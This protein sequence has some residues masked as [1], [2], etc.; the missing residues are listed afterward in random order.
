MSQQTTDALTDFGSYAFDAVNQL[1]AE[2]RKLRAELEAKDRELA[3][4][5]MHL[6]RVVGR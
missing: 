4:M 1:Q 6:D 5:Q 2:V 3:L